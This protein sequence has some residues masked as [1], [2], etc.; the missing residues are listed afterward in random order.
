LATIVDAG[1]LA[2][3]GSNRQPWDFVVVTDRAVIQLIRW[4]GEL[5]QQEK[6]VGGDYQ[7]S[8]TP[9]LLMPI[10]GAENPKTVGRL[11]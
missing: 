1:R 11:S 5:G 8:G 6:S 3:T 7:N 9:V 2:A 4:A 10:F